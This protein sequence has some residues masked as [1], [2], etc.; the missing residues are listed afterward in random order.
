MDIRPGWK[1]YDE[2]L[3]ELFDSR[4][5]GYGQPAKDPTWQAAHPGAGQ[6]NLRQVAIDDGPTFDIDPTDLVEAT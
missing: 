2:K 4:L 5:E 1:G 3:Y 6:V